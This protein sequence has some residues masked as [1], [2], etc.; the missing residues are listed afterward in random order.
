MEVW[1]SWKWWKSCSSQSISFEFLEISWNSWKLPKCNANI[2][3]F[4]LYSSSLITL[5][6]PGISGSDLCQSFQWNFFS[7]S[8]KCGSQTSLFCPDP[9]SKF[10]FS[11]SLNLIKRRGLFSCY[12]HSLNKIG[13][14]N[15]IRALLSH[16]SYLLGGYRQILLCYGKL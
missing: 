3:F 6:I 14:V 5:E 2:M 16:A 7:S 8:I 1:N 13:V 4:F 9:I 15:F 11:R 10:F 12:S